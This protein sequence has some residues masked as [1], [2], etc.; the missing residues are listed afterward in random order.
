MDRPISALEQDLS[1]SEFLDIALESVGMIKE[2]TERGLVILGKDWHVPVEREFTPHRLSD[3]SPTAQA[4]LVRKIR[5]M[6]SDKAWTDQT[7]IEM[8]EGKLVVTQVPQVLFQ[9]GRL[10]EKLN[11]AQ[12]LNAGQSNEEAINVLKTEWALSLSAREQA[13][14]F[15]DQPSVSLQRFI[16]Q[17]EKKANIKVLVDWHSMAQEGWTP[18]TTIPGNFNEPDIESTLRH[19]ARAMRVTYRA[20]DANKFEL[21]TFDESAVRPE[22]QVYPVANILSG[23]MNSDNL[24]E[25][26]GNALRVPQNSI[27]IGFDQDSQSIIAIAPQAIQRQLEAVISRIGK[28]T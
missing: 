7:M 17:L 2:E 5:G 8:R 25:I 3:N 24:M 15:V 18:M 9:I 21:L 23:S 10:L 12:Q 19:L 28:S 13:I 16:K 6:F 1:Y 4:T 11:A 27:Q 14:Q 26:L 20:L 22:L